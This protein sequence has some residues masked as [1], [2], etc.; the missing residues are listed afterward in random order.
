QPRRQFT[1]EFCA[2]CARDDGTQR[3][4]PRTVWPDHLGF[5]GAAMQGPATRCDSER[6]EFLEQARFSDSRLAGDEQDVAF[7][8]ERCPPNLVAERGHFVEP[9][10]KWCA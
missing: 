8:A 3:V 1:G 10:D 9:A 2:A 6:P 7:L 5:E 4:D